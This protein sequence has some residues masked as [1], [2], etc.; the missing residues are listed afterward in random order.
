MK[1]RIQRF[2]QGIADKNVF[3]KKAGAVFMVLLDGL[4][5]SAARN[6]TARNNYSR[7][8]RKRAFYAFRSVLQDEIKHAHYANMYYE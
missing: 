3:I 8:L 4:K 7:R 6:R 1:R 2:K 5:T